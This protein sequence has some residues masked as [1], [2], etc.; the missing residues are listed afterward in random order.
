MDDSRTKDYGV[1]VLDNNGVI[2][3]RGMAPSRGAGTAVETVA[4]EVDGVASVID[5]TDA[6]VSDEQPGR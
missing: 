1:E 6:I 5:E 2:T 3:L 4:R